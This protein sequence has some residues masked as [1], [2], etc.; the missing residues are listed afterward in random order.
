[1]NK[2]I[3]WGLALALFC[4]T[5]CA[6]VRPSIQ[7]GIIPEAK[8][9]SSADEDYGHRVAY[10]LSRQ[11]PL[12]NDYHTNE[13]VRRVV[14]RLAGVSRGVND[15]WKVFVYESR[16]FKNAAATRGNFIFVWTGL[17]NFIRN[18]AELATILSHEMAHVL[19][20]HTQ[21]DPS[22][23]AREIVSGIAGQLGRRVFSSQGGSVGM[24]AGVAGAVIESGMKALI[25]NPE[26]Q[27]KEL[28]ADQIG[29]FLMADAGFDPED[30]ISF[31]RRAARDPDLA[32]SPIDILSSHPSSKTRE[33]HLEELLPLA[34]ERYQSGSISNYQETRQRSWVKSPRL[35]PGRHYSREAIAPVFEKAS[36]SSLIVGELPPHTQVLIV[37]A[38]EDWCEI[39]EPIP[40][41][42][43]MSDLQGNGY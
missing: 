38:C 6:P 31:W 34:R 2:N 20:G 3:L 32:G 14:D 11:F 22:E 36:V 25:L 16:D 40:G 21:S 28:E 17:L 29:L 39:E 24:A 41:F 7:A 13:R 1:M 8:R 23:E 18:D 5:S 15:R 10:E 26:L 19:A 12:D 42:L 35:N 37:N 33:K 4:C 43:R 27:R 9:V 30:A